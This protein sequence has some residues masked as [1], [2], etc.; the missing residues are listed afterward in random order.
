M[1]AA[2]ILVVDDDPDIVDYFDF[3]LRDNGYAVA[4]ASS[5]SEALELMEGEG[6]TPDAVLID[7]MMPGRSGLDL[8][9]SLRRDPRWAETPV[10][11][12]TGSDQVLEDDCRS[13]LASRSDVR[14]PEGILAKPVDRRALLDLL[15]ALCPA[16]RGASPPTEA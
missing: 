5:A 4:S 9:V 3:F 14:F 11:M 8:L 16:T 13:Y 10:V 12:I 6:L 15:A 7:V 2:Q 1:L